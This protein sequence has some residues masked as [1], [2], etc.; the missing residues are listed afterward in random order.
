MDAEFLQSLLVAIAEFGGDVA[1]ASSGVPAQHDEP[2]AWS[3]TLDRLGED[4]GCWTCPLPA[5]EDV[6]PSC[7]RDNGSWGQPFR[8]AQL[9]YVIIPRISVGTP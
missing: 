4:A 6:G 3:A 2:S 5:R 8:Y 9:A 1:M 7:T